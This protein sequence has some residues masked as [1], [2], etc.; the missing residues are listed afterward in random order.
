MSHAAP[1]RPL[2]DDDC[3]AVFAVLLHHLDTKYGAYYD[4]GPVSYAKFFSWF[5][6]FVMQPH[7]DEIADRRATAAAQ[8]QQKP[9]K[10]AK[11]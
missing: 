5:K 11:H 8:Q 9:E 6:Q 4:D 10:G 2:E 7:A 1:V 3:E